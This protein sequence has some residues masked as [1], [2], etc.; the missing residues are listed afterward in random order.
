MCRRDS[1]LLTYT[2]SNK[3]AVEFG[4]RIVHFRHVFIKVIEFIQC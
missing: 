3:F 4:L 1:V 2:E